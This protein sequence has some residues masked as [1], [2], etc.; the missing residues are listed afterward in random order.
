LGALK[1]SDARPCALNGILHALTL[2][3]GGV[4][5]MISGLLDGGGG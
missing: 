2:G 5:M 4:L 1:S 3:D